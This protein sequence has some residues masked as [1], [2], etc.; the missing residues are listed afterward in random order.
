MTPDLQLCCRA[1][2]DHMWTSG[3]SMMVQ[4]LHEAQFAN[5][6]AGWSYQLRD[7]YNVLCVGLGP[8][9]DKLGSGQV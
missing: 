7:R 6:L 5:Q 2:I 8:L 3:H 1:L 4:C 9:C